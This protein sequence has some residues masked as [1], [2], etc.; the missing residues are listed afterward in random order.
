MSD[1]EQKK[2]RQFQQSMDQ[3]AE[4]LKNL[5]EDFSDSATKNAELLKTDLTDAILRASNK[6]LTDVQ[7]TIAATMQESLIPAYQDA[8]KVMFR[9]MQNAFEKGLSE[10]SIHRT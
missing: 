8:T 1:W 4:K 2:D 9:Q 7:T 10:G 6:S 5:M 3:M